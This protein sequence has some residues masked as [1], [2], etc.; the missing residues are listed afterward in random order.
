MVCGTSH[1]RSHTKRGREG[2]RER[3]RYHLKTEPLR[4]VSR[5]D[6][7]SHPPLFAP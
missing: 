2:G 3:T 4:M 6:R 1:S 7:L 5:Q